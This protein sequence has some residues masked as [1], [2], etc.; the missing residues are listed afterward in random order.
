[1]ARITA[2]SVYTNTSPSGHVRAPSG[3]QTGFAT[4]SAFDS[5]SRQLGMDPI[6][7]RMKNSLGNGDAP[8][9]G[10]GILRNIGLQECV[11]KAQEW[12][13]QKLGSKG[14]NEGVGVALALWALHPNPSLVN[15]SAT[16][17]ID[18]D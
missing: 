15:S 14:P 5:L 3:P 4:E 1:N 10:H 13:K 12:M 18:T 2:T 6:A 11:D 8:P 17:K 16:V 7:F 9:S